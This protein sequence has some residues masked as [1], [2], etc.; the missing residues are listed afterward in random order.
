[1]LTKKSVKPLVLVALI[2]LTATSSAFSVGIKN[3]G[4]ESISRFT[5]GDLFQS[6]PLHTGLSFVQ[7]HKL[8]VDFDKTYGGLQDDYFTLSLAQAIKA[9]FLSEERIHME[10]AGQIFGLSRLMHTDESNGRKPME[11]ADMMKHT[12]R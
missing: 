1:M 12:V 7:M 5:S 11:A 4:V 8:V 3:R 2:L 9:S 10:Q 6:P